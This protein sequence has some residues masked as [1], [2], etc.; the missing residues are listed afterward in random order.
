MP[1]RPEI[2]VI[3]FS[4]QRESSGKKIAFYFLSVYHDLSIL[5][6]VGPARISALRSSG[7]A[8]VEELVRYAT[9]IVATVPI[10]CIYPFA[11]RYFITG[12]M[13]GSLK[14]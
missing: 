12:V 4:A 9:I 1:L 7:V 5:P 10:L 8:T 13:M 3:F 6:H 14:E 11:Q 2:K